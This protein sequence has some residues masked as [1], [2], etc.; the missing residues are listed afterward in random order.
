IARLLRTH[1]VGRGALV[2]LALDRGADMLAALLG[3]LKSGAGYVP[4]DP[5]FPADRLAYMAADA[6]LAALLTQQR[7]VA[8][9]DLGGRPVLALDALAAELAA[10]PA[11]RLGRDEAAADPE[12][13]AYVIYTS[14]STGRPKGV[15]VPH[16][17]RSE[18]HT[19]GRPSRENLVCPLLLEKT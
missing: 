15:Q 10:L 2:G 1:G 16:R 12:S 4:L 11:T 18:E 5:Q 14:G 6:G 7:H 8:G 19:P 17:A 3:I 13:P 9:F